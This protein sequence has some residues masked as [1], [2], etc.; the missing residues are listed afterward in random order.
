MD[1][2]L[3]VNQVRSLLKVNRLTVYRMLKDG[4]LNGVKIGHEW[5]FSRHDVDSFLCGLGF[6]SVS[7]VPDEA[8]LSSPGPQAK[9]LA[10]DDLP[11]HCV[12]LIQQVFA[13]VAE[14][15]VVTLSPDG[16]PLD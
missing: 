15:G 7:M 11:M 9:H 16:E 8:P 14:V 2:L 12:Q 13:D 5:R 3:T 4:R 10:Q 1:E 6:S